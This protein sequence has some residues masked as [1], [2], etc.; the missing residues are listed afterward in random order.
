MFILELKTFLE[1]N[2]KTLH[3]IGDI[4]CAL[5]VGN[6]AIKNLGCDEV[7]VNVKNGKL[8]AVLKK[9]ALEEEYTSLAI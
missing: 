3:V 7:Y 6:K 8:I 1:Q 9:S 2:V 4:H 5:E